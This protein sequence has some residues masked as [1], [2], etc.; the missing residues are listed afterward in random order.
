MSTSNDFVKTHRV[1]EDT[2]CLCSDAECAGLTAGFADLRDA[3]KRFVRL[4]PHEN[5]DSPFYQERNRRR[6]AYLRHILPN[7]DPTRETS[8]EFIALHHFHPT[9]IKENA[10]KIPKV[11]FAWP[12]GSIENDSQ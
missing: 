7:H 10:R 9:I 3:R 12:S 1:P 11:T 4:P 8:S 5:V 6:E 2:I